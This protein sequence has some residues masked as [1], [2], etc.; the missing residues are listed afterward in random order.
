MQEIFLKRRDKVR[1]KV[2]QQDLDGYLVL[3]PSNRYYLSGFELHD[4]QCNE[5]AGC[6]LIG[7]DGEDYLCTDPRY[8][9]EGQQLWDEEYLFVY[10]ENRVAQLADFFSKKG[11]STLGFETRIMSHEMY[12][13]LD[14]N[15]DLRPYKGLV[16]DLRVLKDEFE[17]ECLQRS[18][19]L[20]HEVFSFC[21]ERFH[22]DLT[23]NDLAWGI[24]KYFRENGASELAFTPIVAFGSHAALPHYLPGETILGTETPVLIDI[25]GRFLDYCSDQTRTFWFGD[26]L[27]DYFSRTRDMVQEAQQLAIKKIRPGIKI[28]EVFNQT[29]E[30]FR[31]YSVDDHFIH[32][33]GHGI[34][35]ETHEYPGLGP[36]NQ[37]IFQEGM[38]VTIEPGLYFPEWGGVRWE[39]MVVIRDDGVQIL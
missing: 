20:N 27:P 28:N 4:P 39:F 2:R 5:S 13:H 9:Q 7:R 18:C 26:D 31:G 30:F 8:Q 36:R 16:E 34:G 10:K 32:S 15:L 14:E 22:P 21:T 11:Y 12:A 35:L 38:V 29:K 3:H 24:E 1:E 33:L 6:V 19:S 37:D 17:I 23:E 25:G